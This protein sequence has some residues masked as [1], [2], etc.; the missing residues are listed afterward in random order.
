MGQIGPVPISRA[1]AT[2]PQLPSYQGYVSTEQFAPTPRFIVPGPPLGVQ[3]M[4]PGIGMQWAPGQGGDTPGGGGAS[5]IGMTQDVQTLLIQ[6]GLVVPLGQVYGPH[7]PGTVGPT[8]LR[9]GRA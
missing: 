6:D 3:V 5:M 8:A 7:R 2:N 9:R 4:A 1:A